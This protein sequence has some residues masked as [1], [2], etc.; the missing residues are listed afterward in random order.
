M[1]SSVP[2]AT[3]TSSVPAATARPATTELA[4]N[5]ALYAD[6]AWTEGVDWGSEAGGSGVSC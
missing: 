6:P 1:T 4:S 5:T 2:A 3:V